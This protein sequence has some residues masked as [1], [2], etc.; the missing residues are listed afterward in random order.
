MFGENDP[1][2]IGITHVLGIKPL[3]PQI[4]PYYNFTAKPTLSAINLYV[5][6]IF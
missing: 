1:T 3:V 2:N 4:H 6:R 5:V